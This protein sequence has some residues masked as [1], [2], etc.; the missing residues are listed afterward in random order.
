[1]RGVQKHDLK[2]IKKIN[3]TLVLFRTL[4]HPP[5]TGVTDFFCRPLGHGR[6]VACGL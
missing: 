1:M 5:T 2:N 6:S 4:T 3:L